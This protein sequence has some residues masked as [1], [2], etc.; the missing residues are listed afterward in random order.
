[1]ATSNLLTNVFGN[2]QDV[3]SLVKGFDW[4]KVSL[5]DNRANDYL[6]TSLAPSFGKLSQDSIKSID[7]KLKIMI[8]GTLQTLA[9]EP[10]KSWDKM[11]SAMARNGFVEQDENSAVNKAT[12]FIK[13]G[14]SAFKFD[15]S[16]DSSIVR[17]VRTWFNQ[18]IADDDVLNCTKID[19]D[20]LARIVA[21]SGATIDSFES[22]FG[23]HE[24]HEQTMIDIG[25]L[26][27]PDLDHPYFKLYRIRLTA[28]SDSQRIL[29]VQEDKNGIMG[30]FNRKIFRPRQEY[31]ESITGA[32]RQSA[33][34][35][36]NALFE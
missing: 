2:T 19:I 23:K 3:G 16:P 13:G 7:E 27:F 29:F 21:Q 25:V 5:R 10:D 31:I 18:L 11:V 35:A 9:Y 24:H 36:A 26:R 15:G 4:S 28:W 14:T 20:V 6:Q 17:E 1:M 34:D 32:A 30:E 8:V 33:I 12:A 22:F